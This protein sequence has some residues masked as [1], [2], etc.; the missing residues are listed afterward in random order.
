MVTGL[1]KIF[2]SKI[3]DFVQAFFKTKVYFFR[4]Q[5]IADQYRPQKSR[6]KA[7]FMM[8]WKRSLKKSLIKLLFQV[9]QKKKKSRHFTTFPDFFQ[10]WKIAG[11]ISRLF[12]EFQAP[13]SLWL[14]RFLNLNGNTVGFCTQ[15][16]KISLHEF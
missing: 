9:C 1:V 4:L 10:V 2:G 14:K 7:F 3:Q 6:H 8:R 11:Q 12:Q 13:R 15:T 5:V 16:Q